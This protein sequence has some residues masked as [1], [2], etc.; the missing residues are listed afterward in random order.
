MPEWEK[1][2]EG[3]SWP[4]GTLVPDCNSTQRKNIVNAY[5]NFIKNSCLNCISGIQG[6]LKDKWD[7]VTIDCTDPDCSDLDGLNSGNDILICDTSANRVGSVLLHEMVHAIDGEELD[8]EAV[9]FAC[10][11]GNGATMENPSGEDWDK[12]FSKTKK[13]NNYR[14]ERVG[15]YVIWNSNTGEV[16]AKKKEGG[17][18]PSG[19]TISKGTLCFQSNLW[20]YTID[21]WKL[22][23]VA[24]YARK[25]PAT[26]HIPLYRTWNGKDHFYTISQTEYNGLPSSYNREGIECYVYDPGLPQPSDHLPLFRLYKYDDHFYTILLTEVASAQNSG[27]SLESSNYGYVVPNWIS[28]PADHYPVYRLYNSSINDHFYS[29]NFR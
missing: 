4:E 25:T 18:W 19:D 14:W 5:N 8:S 29:I 12:F 24:F 9:E 16:W 1:H 27:Y 21:R 7:E 23:G 6:K 10:F 13:L 17:S 20:K 28:I 22:E 2:R 15:E 26:N 11:N 3:G